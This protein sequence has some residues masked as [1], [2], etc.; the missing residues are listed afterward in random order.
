M[1]HLLLLPALLLT[2]TFAQAQL[3][4]AR[5]SSVNFEKRTRDAVKVEVEASADWTRE[6]W[7]RWLKDT[8]NIKLKGDGVF[9]VGKRDNLT[10]KQVPISSVSGQLIDLYSTIL[11]PADTVTELSVWAATGPDTFLAASSSEFASLRSIVQSFGT[12]A[13]QRAYRERVETAEKELAATTKDKEKLEKNRA[14]LAGNTKSNLEKIEQLKQQNLD[15]QR[16][17]ADDSVKLLDNARLLE[18]RQAQL[19]R[20]R[21]RLLN[22]DR[23]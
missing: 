10:A 1:K 19:E 22:L 4:E 17:S 3:Y 8:Y 16:K 6:F 20:S 7:Q 18:L 2:A 9:G 15:N 12:A 23:P 21:T 11:A 5:T 13:R 14:S